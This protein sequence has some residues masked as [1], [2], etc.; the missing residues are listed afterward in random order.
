MEPR[1]WE[2]LFYE[3]DL[4]DVGAGDA[5]SGDAVG[6][7][8][9]CVPA[10]GTRVLDVGCGSGRM[11]IPLARA[12]CEVHAVDRST[13][14]LRYLRR[15]LAKLDVRRRITVSTLDIRE[16]PYRTELDAAIAADDFLTHFTGG[17]DVRAVLS[18]VR[19]SL[20]AGGRFFT[21]L[22]GKSEERLRDAAAPLPRPMM[23]FGIVSNVPTARGP[24]SAAM[25]SL[26]TFDESR[27]LLRS[28]QRY[29]IVR[30]DGDVERSFYRTITQRLW[31][32]EEL[33]AAAP[34]ARFAIEATARY[35]RDAPPTAAGGASLTFVAV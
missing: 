34:D 3:P 28:D 31:T 24:R 22:R 1:P 15:K 16:R 2:H 21:D 11:A 32:V 30:P 4:L 27:R 13:R 9:S 19:R 18:H 6:F 5:D 14:V 8:L 12:S 29:D 23:S 26:E 10:A 20:R 7:Y 35:R 33:A 17:D 25:Q